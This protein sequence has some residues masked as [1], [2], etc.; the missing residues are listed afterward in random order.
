MYLAWVLGQRLE[1]L[2]LERLNATST[3]CVTDPYMS[4]LRLA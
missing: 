1:L 4:Q 2:A 3:T